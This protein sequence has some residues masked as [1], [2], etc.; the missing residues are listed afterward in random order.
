MKSLS[1][2]R[3]EVADLPCACRW[4]AS[5]F[6]IDVKTLLK[7]R[8]QQ[9]LSFGRSV[10]RRAN[11]RGWGQWSLWSNGQGVYLRLLQRVLQNEHVLDFYISIWW[12][13]F[14][15]KDK[16]VNSTKERRH[17]LKI[18]SLFTHDICPATAQTTAVHQPCEWVRLRVSHHE[19]TA[20]LSL[21][22]Q[23]CETKHL[24]HQP[25]I[26]KYLIDSKK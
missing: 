19:G 12:V 9:T 26:I 1:R 16:L 22:S 24:Q 15:W 11:V 14:S 20:V 5:C 10:L 3:A 23:R 4:G 2:V 18:A 8:Q 6:S 21:Q 13:F 17:Q 25:A 7:W